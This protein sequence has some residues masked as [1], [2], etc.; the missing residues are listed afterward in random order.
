MKIPADSIIP[1]EKLTQYLLA[2][3]AKSDKS[4]YLAQVG[5]TQADPE[6]L[7]VAIRQ[8]AA[9]SEAVVDRQDVYGMYLL[10]AGELHGPR[11]TLSVVT[12]WIVQAVD[13][14]CR[15]VTLKPAR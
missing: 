12:V 15:F 2:H 6:A 13:G 10:A 8:L 14:V 1:R 9:A 4:Q 3:R 5:F 11:G 7:Q